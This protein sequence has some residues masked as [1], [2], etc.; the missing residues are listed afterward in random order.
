[1]SATT[2]ETKA[3][4][5]ERRS[6]IEKVL[7]ENW[8]GP[9]RSSVC[10]INEFKHWQVSEVEAL[11][12]LLPAL[13]D[14]KLSPHGPESRPPPRGNQR[15]KELAMK[16]A[17][18]G[19]VDVLALAVSPL[20]VFS[21]T[22]R[23]EGVP[24]LV[25]LNYEAIGSSFFVK[26]PLDLL[27]HA[28]DTG[29]AVCV[30]R[31]GQFSIRSTGYAAISHVWVE[32]MGLEFHDEKVEQDER[33]INYAHFGRIISMAAKSTGYDWFWL[34]LL[35][36]PQI[37]GDEKE[38]SMLRDIKTNVINSL[39]NVYRNAEAVIILDSLTL[40]LSSVDPCIVAAFLSCGRWLTRMWTYQE[41]KLARKAHVVTK[42]GSVDFHTMVEALESRKKQSEV[43]HRY[44]H[45]IHLKF[46]RLLPSDPR[47]ISLADVAFCCSDR[48][49]EN[50]I[51]Y[52]R[53]V[54]ALLNLKWTAGWDYE[55]AM[56]HIIKSRP[57][58]AAR[59]ANLQGMRG[60][61]APYSWAPRY[62]ARLTGMIMDEYTATENGLRGHWTTFPVRSIIKYGPNTKETQLI[63][64]MELLNRRGEPFEMWTQLPHYWSTQLKDWLEKAVPS[65]TARL[66]CARV[67]ENLLVDHHPVVMLMVVRGETESF[68]TVVGTAQMNDPDVTE[69]DGERLQWLLT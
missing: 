56:L 62:L 59:I 61:P 14:R 58:D 27:R 35:A 69:L 28:G 11:F 49:T 1:M 32:T 36:V 3:E 38:A 51:D 44:W 39:I 15:W 65:G 17:M 21:K 25:K 54:F 55:D 9:H 8:I 53:S 68:G 40:Q 23:R 6:Q 4:T 29:M 26:C 47:G 60:L 7:L 2:S 30:N 66:L 46:A 18:I 19:A 41:V 16:T 42:T 48:N 31:W 63:F 12:Q 45:E 37:S 10:A 33:G 5:R 43:E 22:V 20:A 52:A 34:D 50:N 64:H 24:Q 67:P 13:K 57:Q